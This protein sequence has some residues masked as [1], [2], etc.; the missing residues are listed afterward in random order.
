VRHLAAHVPHDVLGPMIRVTLGFNQGAAFGIHVGTWS[1]ILLS[2]VAVL[3]IGLLFR[4]YRETP[5]G[6][7]L[8]AFALALICGG[9][10]GNL[11]DRLTSA[12]GVVDFIDIGVGTV[13]FWTFNVADAGVT[14]GAVLLAWVLMQEERAGQRAA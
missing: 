13:R 6:A 9:A 1:R 11:I 8:R 12:R 2:L 10:I 4:L 3:V 5:P 7:S 14:V